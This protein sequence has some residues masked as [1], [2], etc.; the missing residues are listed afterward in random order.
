MDEDDDDGVN[1]TSEKEIIKTKF[2]SVN[3]THF[4]KEDHLPD[5]ACRDNS[6]EG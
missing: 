5:R 1:K 3:H 4:P 2:D 6:Y